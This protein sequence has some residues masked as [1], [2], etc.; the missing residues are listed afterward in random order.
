MDQNREHNYTTIQIRGFP[1]SRILRAIFI[2]L[3][4]RD[5]APLE[6]VQ[7]CSECLF[8]LPFSEPLTFLIHGKD[9]M[10]G[11]SGLKLF[12]LEMLPLS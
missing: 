12:S 10:K 4:E 11:I 2:P 5:I 8:L 9:F 3:S 6:N 7:V 1:K